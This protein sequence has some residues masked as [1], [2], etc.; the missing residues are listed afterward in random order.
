M[1]GI[2][3]AGYVSRR[4]TDSNAPQH[5][6]TEPGAHPLDDQFTFQ[7][8]DGANDDH[9]GAAERPAGIPP[10]RLAKIF[11]PFFTTKEMYGTGLGLW[12]TKQIVEKHG[13]TIR[14]R[15]KLGRGTVFS[16]VFPAAEVAKAR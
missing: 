11:E 16:I 6:A 12:V 14:V 3:M 1:D 10:E 15:S 4:A 2:V 5:G 9:H 13:A 8:G 7:L